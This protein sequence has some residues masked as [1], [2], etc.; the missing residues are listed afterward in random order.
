[1][2][3]LLLGLLIIKKEY[4]KHE[5]DKQSFYNLITYSMIGIIFGAR[6]GHCLFY[7]FSYYI[8]NPLEIILPVQFT[9]NFKIVG[10]KGLAS[11]GGG[12]GLLMALFLF[13]KKYK[14]NFLGLLD[15]FAVATPITGMFIRI[16]NFFNSEIIGTSSD[17][18]WSVT[19]LRI[20]NIPRHPAQLYEA[21]FYFL[22]FLI[23]F[24]IKRNIGKLKEGILLGC[25]LI[26]LFSARFIIEF[27]KINQSY[28]EEGLFLNMGQILSIPYII[29]GFLIL[30]FLHYKKA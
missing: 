21:F 18:F 24:A 1:M 26:L 15:M 12:I 8:H 4:D 13:S 2:S 11:H 30:I 5:L 17:I 10:F 22:I 9:P 23:L 20:D 19:F 7:D 27:F 6:L 25:L 14:V 29:L 16:G 28:F 3:G